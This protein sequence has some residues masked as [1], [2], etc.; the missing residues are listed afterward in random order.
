MTVCTVEA[1]GASTRGGLTLLSAC[2]CAGGSATQI[3][4]DRRCRGRSGIT[5][6]ATLPRLST[7]G[8]RSQL[9][10]AFCFDATCVHPTAG[11]TRSL[12]PRTRTHG[13]RARARAR[14]RALTAEQPHRLRLQAPPV[15]VTNWRKAATPF[16]DSYSLEGW[17]G[18]PLPTDSSDSSAQRLVSVAIDEHVEIVFV[19]QVAL[20]TSPRPL[21]PPLCACIQ[22]CASGAPSACRACL[23]PKP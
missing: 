5:A 18:A 16:S 2:M 15:L 23:N 6:T 19:A 14:A 3:Q 4:T 20:C 9:C 1:V 10:F 11:D 22:S 21:C 8:G 7:A 13:A 12:S 17:A